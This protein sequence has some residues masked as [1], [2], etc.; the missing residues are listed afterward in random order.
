MCLGHIYTICIFKNLGQIVNGCLKTFPIRR[1]IWNSNLKNS[2]N[3]SIFI[4]R[5]HTRR[6]SFSTVLRGV[7]LVGQAPRGLARG[8]WCSHWTVHRCSVLSGHFSP[9]LFIVEIGA[10]RP[11][12]CCKISLLSLG[13][14]LLK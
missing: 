1:K 2:I 8:A 4:L 14:R 13:G 11:I 10:R 5:P 3:S 12:T 7:V 9:S 6:Y